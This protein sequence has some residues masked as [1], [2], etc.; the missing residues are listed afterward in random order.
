MQRSARS[1]ARMQRVCLCKSVRLR[2]SGGRERRGGALDGPSAQPR[3]AGLAAWPAGLLTRAAC[4]P[5]APVPQDGPPTGP[6]NIVVMKWLASSSSRGQRAAVSPA[7][8]EDVQL[9]V[10]PNGEVRRS[11]GSSREARCLRCP[12]PLACQEPAAAPAARLLCMRNPRQPAPHRH[13]CHQRQRQRCRHAHIHARSHPC[14]AL[15]CPALPRPALPCPALQPYVA[16]RD[17]GDGNFPL[18]RGMVVRRVAL[19]G[20]GFQWSPLGPPQQPYFTLAMEV[21]V[22][23]VEWM[24]GGCFG[25]RRIGWRQ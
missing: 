19:A 12:A 14:P 16:F 11:L 5:P 2:G 10:G 22:L 7:E 9:A 3:P 18:S 15:P 4:R 24:Q 23:G 1:T 8:A 20:G 21:G 25:V 17:M 6:F 13:P